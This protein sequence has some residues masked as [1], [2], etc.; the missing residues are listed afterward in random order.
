MR[1]V[2]FD[3]YGGPEVLYL[4]SRDK[5]APGPGEVLIRVE[6]IGVN[7]AD[8]K[9]RGGMFASFAP[10]R[11]PHVGGYDVAGVIEQSNDPRLP[12]GARVA[13]MLD[14]FSQG[15]YAEFVATEA[16]RVAPIPEG[17]GFAEAAAAPT[18]GLTGVQ[19]VEEQIEAQAG[20]TI[21]VTGATGFVGRFAVHAAKR[22]GARIVAAVREK[23]RA[24][25][26]RIGA[27]EVVVLG[28]ENWSGPP[29]DHVID[30]VG[31]QAIAA[32]C[33]RLKPGGQI[34]T[35]ATTP[36]PHEGLPAEPVF[37]AVH[38]DASRLAALLEAVAAGEVEI[39]I[40]RELPLECAGEAHRL[41][42]TGG[43]RG[44]IVLC[45]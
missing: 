26:N 16:A 41:V 4:G 34:R 23:Q 30:T 10:L 24:E 33:R 27:D 32:L 20:D 44:K 35:A 14:P 29:F 22:R 37:F 8:A 6:R 42:E 45:P 1:V 19:A 38:P 5:P 21:L 17:L 28:G 12:P 43:L 40:E 39:G 2:M 7:P 36:I 18:P 15:G 25:A 31:G 3:H 9:W 11:F 13:A